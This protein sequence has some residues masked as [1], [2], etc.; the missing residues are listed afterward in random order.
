M[1]HFKLWYARE[2]SYVTI[3]VTEKCSLG[4]GPLALLKGK[5]RN[6]KENWN[7][8]LLCCLWQA[9]NLLRNS[10]LL[11]NIVYS[12]SQTCDG[13][14]TGTTNAYLRCSSKI[15]LSP[16]FLP[17]NHQFIPTSFLSCFRK[18]SSPFLY[19]CYRESHKFLWMY[20]YWNIG[21]NLYL[22]H[23]YD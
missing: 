5:S 10:R 3:L 21:L 13:R 17:P 4:L 15:R 7:R 22:Y 20:E 8:C 2:R 16:T 9:S 23:H 11:L 14:K 18:A 12:I 1:A 19:P 6:V